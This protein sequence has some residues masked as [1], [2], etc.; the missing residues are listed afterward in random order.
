MKEKKNAVI[1][2]RT[3]EWIKEQLQMA[4][5]QNKWSVAQTVEEIC[6]KFIANPQ[7]ERIIIKTTDLINA[8]EELKKEGT[9]GA[10]EL[11]IN[12][13]VNDDETDIQKTIEF[14]M[15]ECGGR[16]H[17]SGFEPIIEMTQDQI[18]DIP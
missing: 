18:L 12:L 5:A 15:L 10:V 2:F 13:Q 17:I 16:G 11:F 14:T 7:P 4:A 6:K 3:E 1:T 8:V 9:T